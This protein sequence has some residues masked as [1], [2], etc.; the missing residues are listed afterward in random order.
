MVRTF[1]RDTDPRL[2]RAAGLSVFAEVDVLV[3]RG[4]LVTESAPSLEGSYE[5]A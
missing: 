5:S 4:E 2:H 3:G 1:Y